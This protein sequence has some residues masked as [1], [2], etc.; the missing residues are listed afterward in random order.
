MKKINCYA[1]FEGGGIKGVAFAGALQK[2]EEAG[3][4][5]IG[6]AGASAGAI[7]AFLAA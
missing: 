3:L 2:A 1:V 6:Y 4:N 5:F 7:I